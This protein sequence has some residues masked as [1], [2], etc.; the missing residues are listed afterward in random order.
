[1][2]SINFKELKNEILAGVTTSLAMVPESVAFAFVAGLSPIVG[3]HS[4]FV[5]GLLAAIFGG[6]PG[7][8]SGAA[9]SIAV[10][11]VSLVAKYGTEYLFATVLLMGVI[12]ILI[13]VFKWGKFSRMIPHPVMLGFVNGLA[14]VIFLAQLNQFK[15]K[16][17]MGTLLWMGGSQLY[18]MLLLVVLTMLVT[19]YLPKLTKVI[20]SSLA[21]IVITTI[22]A[23]LVSKFGIHMPNVRD[24]AGGSLAAG[25]PT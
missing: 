17:S 13:G 9:G 4:T 7:M 1:M 24:F 19:H 5:I 12:Q 8:I 25:I 2:S 10:V 6:R 16:D 14:I 11:F 22:L 21:A 20:P 3:L 23:T 18:V 15:V